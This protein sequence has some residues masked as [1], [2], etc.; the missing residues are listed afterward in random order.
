MAAGE[1]TSFNGKPATFADKK[2]VISQ[3]NL[4][5]IFPL[6][7]GTDSANVSLTPNQ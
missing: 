4:F 1:L 6:G 3:K 5:R 7:H 2:Y